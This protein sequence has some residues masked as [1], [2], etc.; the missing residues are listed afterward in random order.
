MHAPGLARRVVIA[1][2]GPPLTGVPAG[3]ITLSAGPAWGAGAGFGAAGGGASVWGPSCCWADSD[4]AQSK[5]AARMN[6]SLAPDSRVYFM[7][8]S[9]LATPMR[10]IT[11]TDA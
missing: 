2:G 5:L 3:T 10:R 8:A 6:V 11:G 4:M 1:C 9:V 7:T